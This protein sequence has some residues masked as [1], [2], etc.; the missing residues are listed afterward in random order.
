MKKLGSKIRNKFIAGLVI[1]GPLGLTVIVLKWI[2]NFFDGFL[3]PYLKEYITWY[4]PGMGILLT[5][6]VVYTIGLLASNLI[7]KKVL[8]LIEKLLFRLPIVK[9]VYSTTKGIFQAFSLQGKGSFKK[10]IFFQYP[11][12]GLWTLALVTGTTT[13]M[14]GEE[15]Y[16]IFFPSTP[17]PTT[18]YL[19]FVKK[20]ESIEANLS[21]EE[22]MKI[23][24]SGG[25]MLPDNINIGKITE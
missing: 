19:L 7:G 6:V 3:R 22:G 21:I 23:L 10:V 16:S 24:I 1:I 4:F 9:V 25:M 12:K 2:F 5:I 11:R 14:N 13:G 17:N 20:K 18:G 15:Y 8:K